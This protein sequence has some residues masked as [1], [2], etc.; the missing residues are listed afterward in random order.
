MV[1]GGSPPA[2]RS[3]GRP[4]L[5]GFQVALQGQGHRR[6]APSPGSREGRAPLRPELEQADS[7][8]R[9]RR[10]DLC[11]ELRPGA[12]LGSPPFATHGAHGPLPC[13]CGLKPSLQSGPPVASAGCR[14]VS[15]GL[16]RDDEVAPGRRFPGACHL[17]T[18]RLAWGS[19]LFCWRAGKLWSRPLLSWRSLSA[20]Q[21]RA[22]VLSPPHLGTLIKATSALQ[23]LCLCVFEAL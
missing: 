16:Q 17:G 11:S 13:S 3:R 2:P 10:R 9:F 18:G 15:A 4:I 6:A 5:L 7:R 21:S 22:S 20:P 23:A 14:A 1:Q 19:R 8:V 12:G